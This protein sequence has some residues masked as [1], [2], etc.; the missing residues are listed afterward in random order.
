MLE[1]S[2]QQ[3]SYVPCFLKR[4]TSLW[5]YVGN[6]RVRAQVREPALIATHADGAVREDV[7]SVLFLEREQ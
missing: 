1:H 5:E 2:A 4:E 7:S 3:Q 6:Y